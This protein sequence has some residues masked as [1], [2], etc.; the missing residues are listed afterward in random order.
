MN[1]GKRRLVYVLVCAVPS[2]LVALRGGLSWMEALLLVGMVALF[3]VLATVI[4]ATAGYIIFSLVPRF[5]YFMGFL[6]D[7]YMFPDQLKICIDFGIASLAGAAV[8]AVS[9]FFPLYRLF[10]PA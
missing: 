8:I 1:F 6:P 10:V 5:L 3:S 2:L 4:G 7:E 9:F